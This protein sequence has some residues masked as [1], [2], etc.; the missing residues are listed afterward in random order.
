MCDHSRTT[1]LKKL[2]L[3]EADSYF[4]CHPN[5]N[6]DNLVFHLLTESQIGLSIWL[7]ESVWVSTDI[8]I[9]RIVFHLIRGGSVSQIFSWLP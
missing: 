1:I 9:A 5:L 7:T 4:P 6:I 3:A 2:S 8:R